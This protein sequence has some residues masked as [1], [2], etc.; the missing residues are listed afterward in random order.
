M[1]VNPIQVETLEY[2]LVDYEQS[3]FFF[4]F[5]KGSSRVRASPISRLPSRAWSFSY[6]ARFARGTEKNRDTARC[7]ICSQSVIILEKCVIAIIIVTSYLI[8]PS[9]FRCKC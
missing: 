6:L 9:K 3:L 5:S 7:L 8:F 1:T 2:L 4:R